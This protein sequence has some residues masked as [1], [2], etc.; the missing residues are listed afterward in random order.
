MLFAKL[1]MHLIVYIFLQN[2]FT[3]HSWRISSH[4]GCWSNC[5]SKR[6]TSPPPSSPWSR[7][8]SRR[9]PWTSSW[10]LIQST[11]K[12]NNKSWSVCFEKNVSNKSTHIICKRIKVVTA[13]PSRSNHILYQRRINCCNFTLWSLFMENSRI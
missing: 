3:F 1:S 13:C 10:A 2:D 12:I 8:W 9:S 5:K 11:I 6:I 7:P 4:W